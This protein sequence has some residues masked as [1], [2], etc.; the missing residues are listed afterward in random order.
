MDD[1][2]VIL[3]IV[4]GLI[5]L[6]ARRKKK[7]PEPARRSRPVDQEDA[8]EAP[9]PVPKT[10][11]ELL[12]E[13][14]GAKQPAPAPPARKPEPVVVDYDEDIP[15]RHEDYDE[16]IPDY[17]KDYR[18]E[19]QIYQVYEQAKAEAFARPSLEETVKLEDTIVRFKQFKGYE[20]DTRR[21]DVTAILKEFRDPQGFK[22][23]F[24]MS[25]I[26]RP[27]F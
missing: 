2:K 16:R 10:F 21:T 13:I 18:K 11:E 20:K 8:Q 24:I 12:R 17:R 27:K 6:F 22:K 4:I 1:L 25:E 5:Y 26:L 7:E 14:E 19:D 9:R 15:D 23:A 3:W